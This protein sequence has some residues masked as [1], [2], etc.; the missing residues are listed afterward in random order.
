MTQN[1]LV[2]IMTQTNSTSPLE[3]RLGSQV[4]MSEPK[5]LNS[6]F[7]A[8]L[9]S[10]FPTSVKGTTTIQLCFSLSFSSYLVCNLST[11]THTSFKIFV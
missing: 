9:A 1:P 5:L 8:A 7:K 6:F 11:Y 4:Y 10:T 3:Y 2:T